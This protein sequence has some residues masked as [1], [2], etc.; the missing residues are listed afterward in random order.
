MRHRI[1]QHEI[2]EIG[3]R[4]ASGAEA[5]I[6]ILCANAIQAAFRSCAGGL[7]YSRAGKRSIL[8]A[9]LACAGRTID[10]RLG[11]KTGCVRVNDTD[12]SERT[13]ATSD[14]YGLG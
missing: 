5:A 4:V 3:A 1:R 9:A 14:P 2:A 11:G 13:A 12:R 8:R 6:G 7:R 10:G